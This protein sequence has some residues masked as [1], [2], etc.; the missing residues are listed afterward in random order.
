[1]VDVTYNGVTQCTAGREMS[2]AYQPALEISFEVRC[3]CRDHC[4]RC[5][6]AAIMVHLARIPERSG[7]PRE[8]NCDRSSSC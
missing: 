3:S 2:C 6:V 1:M 8:T 5:W 4:R 7:G